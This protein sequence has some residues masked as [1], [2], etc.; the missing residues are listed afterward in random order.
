MLQLWNRST[1][2]QRLAVQL[3]LVEEAKEKRI[4]RDV[5]EFSCVSVM[6]ST[7]VL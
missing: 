3:K 5:G 6:H 7:V 2:H 1:Q 4:R